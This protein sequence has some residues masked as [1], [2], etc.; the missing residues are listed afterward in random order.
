MSADVKPWKIPWHLV[1]I[2]FLLSVAFIATGYFYYQYQVAYI[3]KQKEAELATIVDLKVNQIVAW[4]Q[5]RTADANVIFHDRFFAAK[6]EDWLHGVKN[7]AL[8][9][10]ILNYLGSLIIHQYQ[11]AILLDP[12]GRV[13]LSVPE[14]NQKLSRHIKKLTRMAL[15]TKQPVFSDL[16]RVEASKAIQLSILVPL[17]VSRGGQPQPVGVVFLSL[18]PQKFLYPMLQSWPTPSRTSEILLVRRQG[19]EAVVLNELRHQKNTALNLRFPLSKLR[20]PSAMAARGEKGIVEGIDYHGVPVIAA[21]AKVPNSPWFLV[22]KLDAEELYVPIHERFLL[23]VIFLTVS[24]WA[25]GISVVLIWRNQQARFYRRQYEVER[26]RRS[27]AQR[28]EYLTKH[29]NDIIL[30]ADQDQKIVE[31]NEQAVVTYGYVRDE[32]LKMHLADLHPPEARPVLGK[33][34]REIAQNGSQVFEIMQRH[35]SGTTFPAEISCRIMDMEGRIFF[36]NIIRNI[37]E[38]KRSEDALRESEKHLRYLSS[39]L[40]TSQETERKRIAVELHDGLGQALMVSKMRLRAIERSL[41]EGEPEKECED[42]LNYLDELIKNVRCLSHDLMPPALEDL[43]LQA[44]LQY[45]LDEFAKYTGIR[46]STDL[47]DIQALFSPEKQLI[48]YRIFQECLNNITK[49]AHATEVSVAMKREPGGV[50]FRLEDNGKGFDVQKVPGGD[51][52]KRGLGLA[53]MDERVRMMG[54]DLK[55]WSQPGQGTRLQF[56]VPVSVDDPKV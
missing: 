51:S 14:E 48:I 32:L 54:G 17:L 53:A 22:G 37:S 12:Q 45:L 6:V 21:L 23:M 11:S 41:P 30:L 33:Y 19:N 15:D 5:E 52:T 29:A 26:E 27:L 55:L 10:E 44:A 47:D 3:T 35:K 31:A 2:F 40:L 38:R 42:L 49:H 20:L 18:D 25:A 43:G 7:P 9:K 46:L 50:S 13:S 1:F 16:Y 24:I 8:K 39:Q 56:T 4:R 36:Y 34:L 28:Y